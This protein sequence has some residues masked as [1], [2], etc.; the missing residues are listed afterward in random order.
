MS[1]NTSTSNSNK[2]L[3]VQIEKLVEAS[4]GHI[5]WKAIGHT[6]G[7]DKER[8]RSLWRRFN[9]PQPTSAHDEL[10]HLHYTG[11]TPK[12]ELYQKVLKTLRTE[13]TLGELVRILHLPEA[14]VLELLE[15]IKGTGYKIVQDITRGRLVFLYVPKPEVVE[16]EIIEA[17]ASGET[18]KVAVLSDTHM[19][20]NYYDGVALK[21]F[22]Q[23]AY[24]SGVRKFYHAGDMTDG[25]YKNRETNWF[26]QYAHGFTQQVNDVVNNYPKMDGVTTTFISGN[27][28]STHMFNGGANIGEEIAERRPDMIYKGHNLGKVWL[29]D[30]IDLNLIHP[31]DGGAWAVTHKIQKIIDSAQGYKRAK[32]MVV[33][34]YH[35]MAY[36][37]WKGVHGLVMP[38]F[39]RQTGFMRDNNLASYVGGIIVTIKTD[40]DGNMLSFIPEFV[41]FGGSDGDE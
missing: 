37:E 8:A 27:H 26:E 31:T 5:S 36:I 22:Y 39:Q 16:E 41:D 14:G 35:K 9:S 24:D 18:I 32:I 13:R 10:Y 4:K 23:Y 11:V 38:S 30:K 1:N 28:D 15:E 17:Y 2:E 6:L 25:F 19:G 21:K 3:L 7:I 34:H 12:V 33:G 29:S 20:S 40:R